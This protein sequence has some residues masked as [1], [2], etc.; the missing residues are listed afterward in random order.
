M[1]TLGHA[2]AVERLVLVASC[3]AGH[4]T[5]RLMAGRHVASAVVGL[6]AH[7]AVAKFEVAGVVVVGHAEGT[8]IARL[9]AAHD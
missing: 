9:P 5:A 6:G 2:A 3:F 4:G 8:A 7:L 1:T